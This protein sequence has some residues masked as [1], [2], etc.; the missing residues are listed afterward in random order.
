MA[1]MELN[2][3]SEALGT[4]QQVYVIYPQES[5]KGAIGANQVEINGNIK[6]LYLLHGLSDNHT[7]W[8]RMTSIERYAQEYGLC[9]VMPFADRSFYCD[10]VHGGKYYTYIAHELPKIIESMFRVSS[11]R[12]DRFLAGNSMGGYGALKIALRESDRFSA[13]AALSPVSDV[14]GGCEMFYDEFRTVFGE[15]MQI[16]KADDLFSLAEEK[17]SD[18][19]KPRIVIRVGFDD[20]LYSSTV[21]LREWLNTKSFDFTYEELPGSHDWNF[22]NASLKSVFEWFFA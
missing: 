5:T 18:L 9:I 7:T 11:K 13:V 4:Q 16:P 2:L 21:K 20:F 14:C 3:F 15:E 12:E 1:F 19:N 17:R 6:T 22:W 8:M 10:M